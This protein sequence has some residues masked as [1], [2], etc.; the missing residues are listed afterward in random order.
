MAITTSAGRPATHPRLIPAE[1]LRR[2]Q[3]VGWS[4][5]DTLFLLLLFAAVAVCALVPFA[6][7]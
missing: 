4:D 1:H 3:P 5:S 2:Q 6:L 7:L